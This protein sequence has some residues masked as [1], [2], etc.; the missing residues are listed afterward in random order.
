MK[1]VKW[2]ELTDEELMKSYST[3]HNEAFEELYTRH[4]SKVYGFLQNRLRDRSA[5]DE[6]FQNV[7]L[8]LHRSRSR[9]DSA[10]PF[11]PWLFTISRTVLMDHFRNTKIIQSQYNDMAPHS[12]EIEETAS[13]EDQIPAISALSDTQ[14]Q[15]LD[16]RFTGDHS[17]EEIASR[18][19]T[20]PTNVR[21]IV[22]R[23]IRKLRS[24]IETPGDPHEKK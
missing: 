12:S 23:S 2:S 9:Y 8:K 22:S 11:V 3:G 10:L 15:V 14:K 24:L 18:L 7:F 5:T 4:S 19:D 6:V 21:Q 13:L 17:F 20:S 1:G 16:L